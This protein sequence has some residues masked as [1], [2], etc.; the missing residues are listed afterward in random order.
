MKPTRGG[1]REGAGRK[2]LSASQKRITRSVNLEGDAWHKLDA[3]A[4]AEGVSA[5]EIVNRWAK[6]LRS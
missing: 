2:P 5:S 6:R 3:K 1:K 4:A